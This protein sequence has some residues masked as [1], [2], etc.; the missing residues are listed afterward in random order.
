MKDSY[1]SYQVK[2]KNNEE[3]NKVLGELLDTLLPYKT[4]I[5]KIA[6]IHDAYIYFGL[7]SNLGRKRFH[8]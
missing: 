7:S 2:F 8:L 4:F 3:L 5:S 1:W 6:E